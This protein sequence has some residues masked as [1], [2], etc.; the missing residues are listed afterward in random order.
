LVGL[1]GGLVLCR[2]VQDAIGVDIK[3]YLNLRNATWCRGNSVK[4]ELAKKVIVLGHGTLTLKDLDQ[5]AWLVVCIGREGLSLL[6]W[7]C[8]VPFDELGHDS[9]CSF[10]T[11]GQRRHVQQQEI[12]NLRRALA[13]EDCCLH[14]GTKCHC[15]IR[16]DRLAGFLAVE[17]FLDH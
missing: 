16:V 13:R 15:F 9:A 14:R 12:L 2:H 7:N 6:G 4:V 3:C 11:H 5:N 10:Q 17:E 1:A 8:S